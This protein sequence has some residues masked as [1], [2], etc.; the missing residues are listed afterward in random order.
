MTRLYVVRHC[1]AEGQSP[2]APLTAEGRRQ[3]SA[4]ADVL[5]REPI[6]RIIASPFLRA[7]QT[8]APLAARLGLPVETDA[9]LGERVLAEGELSSW[10]SALRRSFDE[11][12]LRFP[13][14][15]TTREAMARAAAAADDAL[16]SGAQS[17]VLVTHGNLMAL[18]LK[19]FDDRIGFAE[20]QA[21]SN[22]DVYVIAD[23]VVERIWQ[24]SA[25]A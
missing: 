1:K 7:Q 19:R 18:L 12:D 3:A 14:G 11:P 16:A 15:E 22:P 2:E 17:V 20:W 6:D 24:K 21:L 4:L 8:A 25:G 5:A 13:G 9:R 10:M 23:G